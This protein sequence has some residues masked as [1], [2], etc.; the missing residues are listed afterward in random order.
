[1]KRFL[2]ILI[3]GLFVF[4]LAGFV[5][6]P[7]VLRT[8]YAQTRLAQYVKEA[9]RDAPV[10]ISFS[11]ILPDILSCVEISDL[12]ISTP[13]GTILKAESITVGPLLPDILGEERSLGRVVATNLETTLIK[14]SDGTWNAAG[15]FAPQKKKPFIGFPIIIPRILVKDGVVKLVVMGQDEKQLLAAPISVNLKG[16]MDPTG[17]TLHSGTLEEPGADGH[18][19]TTL[20]VRGSIDLTGDQQLKA[21]V[22][23]QAGSIAPWQAL[24]PGLPDIK[25]LQVIIQAQGPLAKP[26]LEYSLS[27][28]PGQS[29]KGTAK[30]D[31]SNPEM[32]LQVSAAFAALNIET[33]AENVPG[34]VNG[35]LE[36]SA[37]GTWPA[38]D[39]S[40]Q[41]DVLSS[42]VLSYSIS[43]ARAELALDR[44][45]QADL[46]LDGT[47][48]Q[49]GITLHTEGMVKGLLEQSSPVDLD[50]SGKIVELDPARFGKHPKI[51]QGNI[52]LTFE[53]AVEKVSGKELADA[54]IALQ[55]NF[56]PSKIGQV[57]LASGS[58]AVTVS[59]EGVAVHESTLSGLDTN[60]AFSGYTDYSVQGR[61]KA[62]AQI[63]NLED[64]TSLLMSEPV[65]GIATI[66]LEA[67]GNLAKPGFQ[68]TVQAKDLKYQEYLL[69]ETNLTGK[70]NL[71]GMALA[72]QGQAKGLRLKG[73]PV[74][75]LTL[76]INMSKDAV[77]FTIDS[78]GGVVDSLSAKGRLSQ[79]LNPEKTLAMD[80]LNV[81]YDDKNFAIKEPGTISFTPKTI[82]TPGL[83]LACNDQIIEVD[84]RYGFDGAIDFRAKTRELDLNTLST[85]AGQDK[86]VHGAGNLNL[87]LQGTLAKPDVNIEINANNVTF[88]P[89]VPGIALSASGHYSEGLAKVQ[90]ALL[91]ETGG[92]LKAHAQIL[93]DLGLPWQDNILPQSGLDASFTGQSLDLAFLPQWVGGLDVIEGTLDLEGV[94]TGNPQA[95]EIKGEAQFVASTLEIKAWADPIRDVKAK[96]D[97]T[98]ETI[99]IHEISAHTQAEGELAGSGTI[100]LDHLKPTHFDISCQTKKFDLAYGDMFQ[101]RADSD[102]KVV[103]LWPQIDVT[104]T[105]DLGA[106]EFRLDRFMKTRRRQV[107]V[108]KDIQIV[109]EVVQEKESPL[110]PLGIDVRLVVSGPMWIRGEGAQIQMG[111]DLHATKKRQSE[112]LT[113]KGYLETKRGVYEFRGKG[114]DVEEGRVDFVGL[115]PPDPILNIKTARKVPGATIYLE[116][117]GVP[118]AMTLALS[119][120]PVMDQTDI[121]SLLIFGKKTSDLSGGESKTLEQQGSAILAA[122]ALNE[123]KQAIGA[124]IPL[125]MLSVES[126]DAGVARDLVMGKYLSPKLFI[127]YRR[128][129]S[130]GGSDQVQLEYQL[131]PKVS[132]ES[133][134]GESESGLDFFWNFDY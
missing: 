22:D 94:V 29:V 117:G 64:L 13:G 92:H 26:E 108:E 41:A 130:T 107:S 88:V 112:E 32:A 20:K 23:A 17:F 77:A 65:Q 47:V 45:G 59:R 125:D 2:R 129:M 63:G 87:E 70:G 4:L 97:W 28:D 35:N 25:N 91:P 44:N 72:V 37:L 31:F 110:K 131:T 118:S 81:G 54:T 85:L 128:Q 49:A 52:H 133:Q 86:A 101:T 75:A 33:F 105:V 60:L 57:D 19:P 15:W 100:G 50:L 96:L 12:E 73:H 113:C 3:G 67:K 10:T 8:D 89:D 123:L 93:V 14:N 39:I 43:K 40:A 127:T 30:G 66:D 103:G 78:A 61:I 116:I 68:A 83:I 62:Q 102:L 104:G 34:T 11:R 21:R 46:K 53:G 7:L 48:N 9:T 134:I 16:S 6:L 115:Y 80:S 84:G 121:A 132:V 38:M 82:S 111:G 76:D 98:P 122:Q 36:A 56:Q 126:G 114:F 55:T 124:N 90:A 5:V 106:G 109:G 79:Y 24:V 51:P 74:D 27:C 120:D 71:E 99:T 18:G 42:T 119:A 69:A 1:M 58:V 95:P